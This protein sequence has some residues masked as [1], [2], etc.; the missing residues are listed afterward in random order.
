MAPRIPIVFFGTG[1]VAAA[2]LERLQASFTIEA[3]VTKP[4]PSHHKAAAPVLTVA[5]AHQLPVLLAADKA[6]LTRLITGR[7]FTSRVAVLI[8]YGIIVS[9]AVIDHFP[10]GIVNSHFSLLPQWRG[11]DPISFAVLS[12]QAQTG[13]SL[14]LLVA[15]MDQGPLLA[16]MTYDLPP[17]ITT[18]ELTNNLIAIS[19]QLL[20]DSLPAYLAGELSPQ[21]QSE[22][23]V[24]YSRKLS[25]ADAPLLA[26]KPAIELEREVRAF[27]GWPGSRLQAFGRDIIVTQA[28]AAHYPPS[29]A[30]GSLTV[31]PDNQFL[32]LH[33]V[34][35]QLIIS[36]LKPAG[37]RAM[38]AADFLRG[39]NR[40]S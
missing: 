5:E 35:G 26:S 25:K 14:M 10:A 7:R 27:T 21:P 22:A 32:I 24:S 37:K 33:T 28:H 6:E 9:Q 39:I 11:A 16:R 20:R 30:A 29:Q 34:D 13:V 38:P 19:A 36:Q 15:Q 4:T 23:G 3:V 1:P 8:D 31:S 40:S 12:G 18:P 2:S 17:T